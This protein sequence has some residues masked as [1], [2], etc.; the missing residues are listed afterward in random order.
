[1]ETYSLGVQSAFKEISEKWEYWRSWAVP[2]RGWIRSYPEHTILRSWCQQGRSVLAA[3]LHRGVF[4][5]TVLLSGKGQPL[6][7]GARP[8]RR[9]CFADMCYSFAWRFWH[10]SLQQRAAA[11]PQSAS[12]GV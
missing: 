10:R 7:L 6:S 3:W 4:L 1:M 2:N 5:F 9:L 11:G 8:G 12:F